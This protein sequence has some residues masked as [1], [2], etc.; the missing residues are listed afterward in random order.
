M[1]M[2]TLPTASDRVKRV[3][4]RGGSVTILGT[5][6]DVRVMK[7]VWILSTIALSL[8]STSALA[9]DANGYL[10]CF[11][12]LNRDKVS[13]QGLYIESPRAVLLSTAQAGKRGFYQIL[14]NFQSLKWIADFQAEGSIQFFRVQP[15]DGLPEIT[16][17]TSYVT[18]L[19]KELRDQPFVTLWLH[20]DN[21]VQRPVS[22]LQDGSV[23]NRG[24]VR[25]M[26]E[27]IAATISG[28]ANFYIPN[29]SHLWKLLRDAKDVA[30]AMAN[31]PATASE[32]F[33]SYANRDGGRKVPRQQARNMLNAMKTKALE[34][35]EEYYEN[36]FK[37]DPGLVGFQEMVM[38]CGALEQTE[39]ERA[40]TNEEYELSRLLSPMIEEVRQIK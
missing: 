16:A 24:L 26:N 21:P 33:L 4:P 7:K 34:L 18:G 39:I 31:T 38:A 15:G 19:G 32:V 40:I 2:A 12:S 1:G 3:R 28:L 25:I 20:K 10:A 11:K 30:K 37:T 29:T 5:L 17:Q 6:R 27:R 22:P 14:P 23:S 13:F 36:N 8:L 35:A 9:I